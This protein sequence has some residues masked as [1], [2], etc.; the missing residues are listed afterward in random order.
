MGKVKKKKC[1]KLQL[2][3]FRGHSKSNQTTFL[4]N[5]ENFDFLE[6]SVE[7]IIQKNV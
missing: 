6:K 5:I 4:V 2:T 3:C 1:L 7:N